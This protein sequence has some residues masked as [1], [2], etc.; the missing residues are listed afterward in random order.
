MIKIKAIYSSEEEKN[1][2][3]HELQNEFLVIKVSKEYK[4]NGPY[5][6]VH[7]EIQN[8]EVAN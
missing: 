8:K 4:N 2:F 7:I 3:L 5:K 6:R 1:K